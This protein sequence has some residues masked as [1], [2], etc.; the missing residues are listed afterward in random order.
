MQRV[1]AT[2]VKG[3]RN[4]NDAQELDEPPSLPLFF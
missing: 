1:V 4:K 2:I 3:E